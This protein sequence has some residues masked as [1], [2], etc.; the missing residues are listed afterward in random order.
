MAV[1]LK[2]GARL[3]RA[4]P[5]L[6]LVVNGNASGLTRLGRA[7]PEALLRRAGG[8]VEVVM[9]ESVDELATAWPQD[10]GRRV[11]LVGGD[12]TVHAVANLPGAKPE[13]ALI[14]AGRANNVARSLG[15]PLDMRRAA[16]LAVSGSAR[17]I[18][19]IEATLPGRRQLVVEGVSVGFLALARSRYH[20]RN[21]AAIVSGLV[22]GA[23][24]LAHFQ[25]LPVEVRNGG[26]TESL[27]LAQLFVANLP[28]YE[29]GLRVAPH[30][31]PGD[32]TLDFV[33]IEANGRASIPAML[34]RLRRAAHVG[35][36]GVHLWRAS[37][38]RIAT[39][40][41][42][43]IVGDSTDLGFGPVTVRA[44]SGALPIVAPSR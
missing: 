14:P 40:G 12:G 10:P 9:T 16:D 32:A 19:V 42:S 25:P 24:A 23:G 5:P 27:R 21:S 43:P 41:S 36:P 37:S 44:L 20:E 15:I 3:A 13:L 35:R 11:V 2:P 29:F 6:L 28:L 26:Q 31:D 34:A 1:Q 18:D 7:F 17:S 39:H 4:A 33:G 8:R 22:A 30:A 38:A